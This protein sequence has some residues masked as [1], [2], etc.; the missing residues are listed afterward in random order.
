MGAV[1]FAYERGALL[2]SLNSYSYA[3]D[4]PIAKSDPSG[5]QSSFTDMGFLNSYYPGQPTSS[6]AT[7]T[8]ARHKR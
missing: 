7:T 3:S 6:T 1:C 5:L 2:Q 8:A 4:N